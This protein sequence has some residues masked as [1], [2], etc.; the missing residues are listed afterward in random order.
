[1]RQLRLEFGDEGWVVL[2]LGVGGFELVDGVG[3]GFADEAAAIDAEMA[4]E[5]GLLVIK[6]GAC[7]GYGWGQSVLAVMIAAMGDKA[8]PWIALEGSGIVCGTHRLDK[9]LHFVGIFE[10]LACFD[11]GAHVNGQRQAV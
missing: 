3:Q 1:V 6:H 2:V 9:L 4:F 8:S 11:A 5:V 7:S 10:A